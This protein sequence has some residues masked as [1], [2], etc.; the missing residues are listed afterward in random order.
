VKR[1]IG[2]HRALLGAILV[3]A[4]V[5]LVASQ[6]SRPTTATSSRQVAP[7]TAQLATLQSRTVH[8]PA[9]PATDS[10]VKVIF[11]HADFIVT[12]TPSPFF[13]APSPQSSVPSPPLWLGDR[14][15]GRSTTEATPP[16]TVVAAAP[17]T[18][19]PV[20]SAV[21]AATA[22]PSAPVAAPSPV[23]T[24]VSTAIGLPS[25]GEATVWGCT[26][27]L[28]Y[29]TAY[30]A[31]G[32]DLECP[33]YAQGHEATT[34]CISE[35]SLCDLGRFIE[36]ADPCPAAYMNEASNSWVLLGLSDASIDPYGSCS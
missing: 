16:A 33:A 6:S 19:T 3:V 1:S 30:A 22:A 31:P 20:A 32:F 12:S 25:R 10:V 15:S 28:A 27:A 24:T 21:P 35:H 8:T 26:A 9:F 11:G 5:L 34:T 29:L 18:V 23:A 17:A 36:I 4:C 14:Q 13:T 7:P 2:R